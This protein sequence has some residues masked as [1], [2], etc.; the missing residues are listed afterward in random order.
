MKVSR[1]LRIATRTSKLARVQAK[2]FGDALQR[3]SPNQMVEYVPVSTAGDRSASQGNLPPAS[4]DDFVSEIETA[5][6]DNE[7]DLAIHSLKDVP[8]NVPSELT[9]RTV[10]PREDPRDVLVGA[11]NLFCLEPDAKIGTSSPRRHALLKYHSKFNNVTPVRGNVDT[12]LHKLDNEEYDAILLAA[13]GLHRIR[14][15]HR[16]GSYLDP[17]CFIPAPCQ[18]TLAAEYRTDDSYVSSVVTNVQHPRV[19]AA[20]RC[21]R[22]IV[23][24]LQADCN[25][26]LGVYCEDLGKNYTVHTIALNATG[27]EV[28]QLRLRDDDPHRLAPNVANGLLALGVEAL[29]YS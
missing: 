12:R 3:H 7:A 18:G 29:L 24:S 2:S 14:L 1:I 17:S 15:Q 9:I 21:E 22:S 10:L 8:T 28:L 4:K 25:A 16:I 23:R 5:L 19:E 26:A 11:D 20:A 13:A 27:T 6:L